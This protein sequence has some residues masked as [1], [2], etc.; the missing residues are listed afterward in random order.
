M[1]KNLLILFIVF[2]PS[3]TLA[4]SGEFNCVVVFDPNPDPQGM[5]SYSTT[6]D[7]SHTTSHPLVLNIKFWDLRQ[8][9]GTTNL[10]LTRADALEATANLNIVYNE[11]NIFFKYLDFQ[12]VDDDNAYFQTGLH[13]MRDRLIELE[14]D[15]QNSLNVILSDITETG[16]AVP[17][18][19]YCQ[20][21]KIHTTEWVTIHEI[22]HN[23]GLNHT[24]YRSQIPQGCTV[25]EHVTRDPNNECDPNNDPCEPCFNATD[26][27]DKV[28]DTA[29]IN[30]ASPSNN[31]N[32]EICDYEILGQDCQSTFY[33]LF[34]QDLEN[35]MNVNIPNGVYTCRTMLTSGQGVRMRE[36]ILD[37][38]DIFVPISGEVSDLYEHYTGEYYV[39]GPAQDPHSWPLYQPGFDYVFQS[40]SCANQD[41]YDCVNGPCDFDQT[42]FQ[43]NILIVNTVSKY[44]SDYSSITHPNHSSIYIDQLGSY[45]NRR[46]YDNWNRAALGG[47]VV[48]FNDG[49]INTNI[50]INPQDSRQI[51]NPNLIDN[52]QQGLYK[53]EKSYNDGSTQQNVIFKENN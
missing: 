45:G 39:S 52:L 38:P 33:D 46:C 41:F 35:Y 34:P 44:E 4:Q 37:R 47:S 11:F 2:V 18:G 5:Y 42:A 50:T 14:L 17:L 23:L 32:Y 28:T 22:G 10:L 24:F 19:N 36:T 31:Y 48:Q 7:P 1:K 21:P 20:V 26:K 15:T 49:V 6:F 29:A 51:N 40:C 8:D 27:G 30:Q 53:I 9:D 3:L 12:Y 43:N 13:G 16:N 25:C